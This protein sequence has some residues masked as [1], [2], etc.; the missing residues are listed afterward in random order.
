MKV[1]ALFNGVDKVGARGAK[2]PPPDFLANTIICGCGH[3][4]VD[5][6]VQKFPACSLQPP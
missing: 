5:V 4:K 3:A 6:V 2:A 1:Y